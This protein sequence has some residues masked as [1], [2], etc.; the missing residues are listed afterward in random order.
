MY[1]YYLPDNVDV[2]YSF[3]NQ[4]AVAVLIVLVATGDPQRLASRKTNRVL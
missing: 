1:S 4:A 3:K 2:S